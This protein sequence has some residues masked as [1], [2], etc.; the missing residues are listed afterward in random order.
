MPDHFPIVYS[1]TAEQ[2]RKQQ[3]GGLLALFTRSA[4]TQADGAG[5]LLNS[6]HLA[7]ENKSKPKASFENPDIRA[8]AQRLV[9]ECSVLPWVAGLSTPF[10]R[11][12]VY[13]ILPEIHVTYQD[14]KPGKYAVTY[15]VEEMEEVIADQV[16]QIK[17]IGELAGVSPDAVERDG[18]DLPAK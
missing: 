6:L 10:Y 18:V 2:I 3:L 8:F 4:V 13:T 9:K 11:E 17:G 16:K 12:I 7:L 14:H 15:R 1:F 5:A